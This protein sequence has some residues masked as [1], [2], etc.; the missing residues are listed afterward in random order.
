MKIFCQVSCEVY[1]CLH[2]KL[3]TG[4]QTWWN[5]YKINPLTCSLLKAWRAIPLDRHNYFFVKKNF[6]L[7]I[8]FQCL[9]SSKLF[10]QFNT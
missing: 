3:K 8:E 7:Q 5:Y 6:R 2:K 10:T 1:E 4:E 9:I